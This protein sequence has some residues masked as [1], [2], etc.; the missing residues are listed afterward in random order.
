MLEG[1]AVSPSPFLFEFLLLFGYLLRALFI[2]MIEQA[3]QKLAGFFGG[4]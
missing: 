1:L 4:T 2:E 3:C